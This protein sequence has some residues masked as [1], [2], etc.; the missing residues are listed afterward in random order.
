VAE[1]RTDPSGRFQLDVEP[2]PGALFGVASGDQ[3]VWRD[4]VEVRAEARV[5]VGD[6]EV[7]A[8]S[9]HPAVRWLRGAGFDEQ[10]TRGA[11]DL[12]LLEGGVPGQPLVALRQRRTGLELFRVDD[13]G[14]PTRL[15]EVVDGLVADFAR[16]RIDASGA[17]TDFGKQTPIFLTVERLLDGRWVV[18]VQRGGF[19]IVTAAGVDRVPIERV[20]WVDVQ[21]GEV[22]LDVPVAST[23]DAV[24]VPSRGLFTGPIGARQWFAVG[25]AGPT[26]VEND[27]PGEFFAIGPH[28]V[29][30]ST[31]PGLLRLDRLEGTGFVL[32]PTVQVPAFFSVAIRFIDGDT[33]GALGRL[34]QNDMALVRFDGSLRGQVEVR[35]LQGEGGSP[36][37]T[38][39][40]APLCDDQPGAAVMGLSEDHVRVVRATGAGLSVDDR[41]MASAPL[42]QVT[43]LCV[44]M[45]GWWAAGTDGPV[46]RLLRRADQGLDFVDLDGNVS[47]RRVERFALRHRSGAS[48]VDLVDAL[49]SLA[50]RRTPF[51]I[52][53]VQPRVVRDGWMVGSLPTAEGLVV[54]RTP[55]RAGGAL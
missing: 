16:L 48:E 11:D 41:P 21:T 6:L 52:P 35:S 17:R 5:D 45:T 53:G 46:R 54:V 40:V 39:P 27:G 13:D 14:T 44:T 3:G 49:E 30:L 22:L 1:T 24:V 33:L 4:D 10:L 20:Q 55:L 23:D 32:G 25:Q 28:V 18:V 7:H 9:S 26:R 42:R 43:D 31:E 15:L 38:S 36:V 34:G 29:R 50:P 47:I 8:V 12:S 19:S 2:G 51:R 37:I